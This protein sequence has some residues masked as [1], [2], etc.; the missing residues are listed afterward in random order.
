MKRAH[1]LI[2]AWSVVFAGVS[3]LGTTG[4][5]AEVVSAPSEV[6]V[7][8]IDEAVDVLPGTTRPRRSVVLSSSVDSRVMELL[9]AEGD[10]VRAGDV[11]AVLDDR[12]A[13]AALALARAEAGHVGEVA[14][15]TAR[16]R[17]DRLQVERLEQIFANRAS[18]SAELE[19]ARTALALSEAELRSAIERREAAELRAIQAEAVFEEQRVRAAFDGVVVR[20]HVEEGAVVRSGDP[21]AEVVD[22]SR[23]SVDLYLPAEAAL[24]ARAGEVYAL[25]LEAP[26]RDVVGARVRYV[27]PRLDATSNTVRVVLDIDRDALPMAIPAGVL[28]QP[29]RTLPDRSAWHTQQR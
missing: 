27:E 6:R 2:V 13:R 29:A 14:A 8:E 22:A 18:N 16:V 12:V 10:A 23:V 1:S 26:I 24:S 7:F 11:V 9:V 25:S 19:D 3:A 5:R 21:I 4:A 15:A 28:A 20:R 17:R